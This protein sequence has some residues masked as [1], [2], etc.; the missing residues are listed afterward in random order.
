MDKL[1]GSQIKA[2]RKAKGMTLQELS[3][4]TELSLSYLSMM[5]RG[6]NSP[7]IAN[8][9]KICNVFDL[10]L[11]ELLANINDHSLQVSKSERQ[12]IFNN[13]N[14]LKY[15]SITKGERNITG[16]II[17]IND[18][19]KHQSSAHQSDELGLILKGSMKMEL[20]NTV[21]HLKEGDSFY[22]P[23]NIQ[24]SYEKTSDEECVSLWMYATGFHTKSKRDF[25]VTIEETKP[26]K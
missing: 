22:I 12:V 2:L 1:I 10:M 5:E 25:P 16:S 26:K 23:A 14:G 6:L 21:Y 20:E 18:K 7:T 24:H 4:K 13:E 8:L 19:N 15:E 11:P 17:T 9:Q 3:K